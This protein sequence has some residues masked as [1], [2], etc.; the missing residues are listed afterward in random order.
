[1]SWGKI[2]LRDL[3][4]VIT[5]GTTPSNIGAEFTKT[6]IN[7]IR[8]E[9]VTASKY[10]S[11]TGMLYISKETHEKLKRSQ[12]QAGDI[13]FSMAGVYLGKTAILRDEDVPANTNQAVALIRTIPEKCY[14][15]YIYY[16]LNNPTIIKS[17]NTI[18]SQSAQP[19]INL[20][21]I[22]DIEISLPP[23]ETQKKIADI[24]SAYD[25]LIENNQ[26]QIKLLEEATQ[27]LY[28][29]WFID[30]HFPGYES[31][32]ISGGIPQGW[33]KQKIGESF[34]TFL[35]GT[36]SREKN[37]YWENGTIS[38][39]N[40]GKVNE[41]R[42]VEPSERITELALQ[43]SATKL[44]PK[45]TTILAITGAT[46]GQVSY[47][48]IETC[49]NQSV[50][51]IVDKTENYSEYIYCFI[52]NNIE[53]IILKATGGAQQHINKEI[54]NEYYILIPCDKISRA[55]K[56]FANPIFNK[57]ANLLN[58][59]IALTEVR[60]RLLPKLMNGEIEVAMDKKEIEKTDEFEYI[61]KHWQA[62]PYDKDLPLAARSTG[63]IS[64]ETLEKLK[65]I[66][67]EE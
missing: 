10:I 61:R 4:S 39:I 64:E 29:E 57:M 14:R 67:E 18:T 7:Y 31:T 48:E 20:T 41:L 65:E 28:K 13:L 8:S 43:K 49:A 35:G 42:V 53:K 3:C 1:M 25:D 58:E 17:V 23:I 2:K 55:F 51:G 60:D 19:N 24:L 45:H 5:K 22:G 40:S 16:F 66:A 34:L 50:V 59:N 27:R 6:G 9:M 47:T 12:L 56:L 62:V 15:D 52:K 44:L 26:K 46:L 37:E 11:S 38:W 30:L 21:Q 32:P 63:D 54:V 33:K 36:P